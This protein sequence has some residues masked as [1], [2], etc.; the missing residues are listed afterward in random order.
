MVVVHKKMAILETI[1]RIMRLVA[2]FHLKSQL[3]AGDGIAE[4][5]TSKNAIREDPVY[6]LNMLVRVVCPTLT[7]INKASKENR[8]SD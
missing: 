5:L 2:N 8:E 7:K 4:Q 3:Q 1:S 6:S